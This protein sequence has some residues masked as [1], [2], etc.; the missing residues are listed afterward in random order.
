[1]ERICEAE[2]SRK[3]GAFKSQTSALHYSTHLRLSL[4][5]CINEYVWVTVV[6][7]NLATLPVTRQ[8]KFKQRRMRYY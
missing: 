5:F 1:M 6:Y 2:E 8:K 3:K 4:N 7:Y